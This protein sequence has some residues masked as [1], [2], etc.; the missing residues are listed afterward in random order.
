MNQRAR[1]L[2]R[3]VYSCMLLVG[4]LALLLEVYGTAVR[5]G[6]FDRPR[7]PGEGFYYVPVGENAY[8]KQLRAGPPRY[9]D[10]QWAHK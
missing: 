3:F 2:S 1:V 6:M 7:G 5:G 9:G 4:V 10:W 8:V